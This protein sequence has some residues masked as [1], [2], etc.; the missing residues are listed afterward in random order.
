MF[1][2]IK[3]KRFSQKINLIGEVI[4]EETL[5]NDQTQKVIKGKRNEC[6]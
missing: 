3:L 1:L 6:C 4:Y 2:N 5:M